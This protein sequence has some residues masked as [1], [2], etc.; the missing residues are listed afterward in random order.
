ML[1]AFSN[2]FVLFCGTV[3]IFRSRAEAVLT[4]CFDGKL[5]ILPVEAHLHQLTDQWGWRALCRLDPTLLD[6][7]GY[8]CIRWT[9]YFTYRLSHVDFLID[10]ARRWGLS[11][12]N[13]VLAQ[14]ESRCLW[15]QGNKIKTL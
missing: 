12:G 9:G 6:R 5:Y 3:I 10:V 4:Q 13:Q 1:E 8:G 14:G 15:N 2:L 7:S 11:F